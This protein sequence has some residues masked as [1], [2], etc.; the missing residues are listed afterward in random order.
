MFIVKNQYVILQSTYFKFISL[1]KMDLVWIVY[2]NKI[3]VWS[4]LK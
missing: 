3:T 1:R 2:K 4:I